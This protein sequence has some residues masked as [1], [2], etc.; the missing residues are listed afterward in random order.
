MK[1]EA[2][3]QDVEPQEAAPERDWAAMAN[4]AFVDS[5]TY[6]D[7]S[8]RKGLEVNYA[9]F[10]GRHQSGS[11]YHSSTYLYRSKLF[12]P[13]T[14]AMVR[15]AEASASLAFFATKDVAT[16]TAQDEA[17][18]LQRDAAKLH[19]ALL[20]LRLTEQLPWFRI[21]MGAVQD[22]QIQG[23]V[24]SKQDWGTASGHTGQKESPTIELFPL[25][26]LR[27]SSAASWV[28]PVG[29]SPFLIHMR[30]MFAIDIKARM[31]P[32]G[33]QPNG[34]E[35]FYMTDGELQSAET[36]RQ[37]NDSVRRAREGLNRTDSTDPATSI[38]DYD[39]I[40]VHHNFMR[41]G[42]G[43]EMVYYTIGHGKLLSKPIPLEEAYP[44]GE[45]PFVMGCHIIETHRPYPEGGVGLIKALQQEVN[46]LANQ[47]RDN[48]SFVM[49][50]RH[51]V[52]RGAGINYRQLTQNIPSSIVEFD[53]PHNDIVTDSPPDVTGSAYAEQDRLNADLDDLSGS[54]SAGSVQTNRSLNE[55]VGGM[56][57]IKGESNVISEY[58]IKVL[59][60]TWVEP[61]LRQVVRFSQVYEIDEEMINRAANTADVSEKYGGIIPDELMEA[62]IRVKV[63]VG[64]GATNP[65]KKIEKM[66]VGLGTLAQFFPEQMQKAN[67]A[68][69]ANEVFG[70]LG[71]ANGDRFFPG[72][73]ESRNKDPEVVA[74][75]QQLE[76]AMEAIQQMQMVIETKQVESQAKLK[77]AQ[78]EAETSLNETAM[79]NKSK[80]ETELM[81][82]KAKL[83][84]TSIRIGADKD[85]F[86]NEAALKQAFGEKGNYGLEGPGAA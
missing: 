41:I 50:K 53:D 6:F 54:F 8:V 19:D 7:T 10:H 30:P 38:T 36:S 32:E 31:A 76:K 22:A 37:K 46:D 80:E 71:Y 51:F 17:S 33:E 18:D 5:T 74:L 68:E 83:A 3:P 35:W 66:A 13:K 9:H 86:A 23:T 44:I 55:T 64:Q 57:M 11:K 29:T 81:K 4:Q 16:I 78:I 43:R 1:L 77:V 14:R 85:Q 79:D 42:G 2:V 59:A 40:W 72:I 48:V 65:E 70:A 28:D 20:N 58:S 27:I 21:C 67:F 56:N 39:V 60:E 61:V 82:A 84:D 24:V 73:R 45:R 34:D 26:N 75:E 63:D 69:V 62:P 47:R 25:E 15:Q 12:R 49:N 52:K